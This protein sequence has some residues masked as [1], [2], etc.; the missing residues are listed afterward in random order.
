VDAKPRFL[1]ALGMT[2]ELAREQKKPHRVVA[3][4]WV[5][6]KGDEVKV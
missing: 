3:D 4:E 5:E 1:A 6:N 2:S